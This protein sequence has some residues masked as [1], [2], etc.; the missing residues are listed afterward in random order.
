LTAPFLTVLAFA[1]FTGKAGLP[2]SSSD[3]SLSLSEEIKACLKCRPKNFM[4]DVFFLKRAVDHRVFSFLY[5][6]KI[7]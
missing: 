6:P 7:A 1:T 5:F 4:T 3:S 2:A